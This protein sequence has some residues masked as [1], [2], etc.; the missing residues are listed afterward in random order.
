MIRNLIL[1]AALSAASLFSASAET[2]WEKVS[3]NGTQRD[4]KVHVPDNTPAGASLVIACHGM[5][6]SADW[7]DGNSK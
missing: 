1:T 3:V 4:I 2:V 7:H 6:Q 5:N